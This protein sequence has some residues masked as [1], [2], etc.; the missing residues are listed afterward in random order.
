MKKLIDEMWS[1]KNILEK[2]LKNIGISNRRM[3]D[4]FKEEYGITIT[5]YIAKL[6]LEEVKILLKITDDSIIDIA[7]S[8]GFGGISSFYRF[9][10]K[11]WEYLLWH[12][13]EKVVVRV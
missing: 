13:E 3:V 9:F 7:Y 10:K 12:I 5:E 11:R 8:V 6:R 4:I 2:Q 1:D